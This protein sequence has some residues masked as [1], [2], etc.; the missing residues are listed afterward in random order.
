VVVT[1][2]PLRTIL[3]N[4]NTTGNIAKW[5]AELAEFQLDFQPR[6]AIKSQ[7]L[8]DFIVEWTPPACAPGGPDLVLGPTPEERRGPIFTEP[9]WTLFF[10][11]SARQQS[12]GAGVVLVGPGGDQLMY[13]VRLEFKAT[14]NMAEYEALIFGLYVALSLGVRQLLVKGDSQLII[15]QVHGEC[16]CNEPRLAAYLLQVKKLEK[17]FMA[18]ELQHVPRANNSAA[19]DLSQRASTRAPVPEG[20]FERRLL[21]P[22]AQPA[23][24][25]EGGETGTSKPVVPV[26]SQNPPKVVCALGDSAD[27]FNAT[28]DNSERSRCMDLR[29][30]GLP[31]GNIL[32]EDHVSTECIVRLAK[33]YTMVEGGLYHRGANVI[34]MWCVTQEEG[35][36]LLTEIHGGE[37]GSHSSSRTLVGKAF[38]HGFYW[39]TALQDAV[40]LVKSCKACQ[41]HAKEIH[42]PAQALQLIPSSW[43]FA[44]WGW[45]SWDRFP[46]LSAGTG[47]SLSPLTSSPSDR[48]PPL[49]Q[50]HPERCCRLP[51]VDRLQIW[52]PKSYHYRQRDPV[53]KSD[54]SGV[55]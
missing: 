12:A 29:D 22:A 42:T 28:A 16:S 40:E 14:N 38:R 36:E 55:L 13:V 44:V 20:V 19:D 54:L 8:A 23:E 31:E 45:I 30:L 4:P 41:H 37:C 50:H 5:A 34:L 27:P 24:L 3:H 53:Y 15:K 25:G 26:A 48:K 35:R 10:D 21:R 6:H 39:P 52:G 43:P 46:G 18:L 9:H 7:V 33:R 1:S 47:T 49:C 32:S 51:Q 17:D 11:G 2:F